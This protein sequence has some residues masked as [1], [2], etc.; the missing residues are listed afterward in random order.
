MERRAIFTTEH[1][2]MALFMV[3]ALL[4]NLCACYYFNVGLKY[5][6]AVVVMAWAALAF[7]IHPD[8]QRVRRYIK[9]Y[10]L[11]YFPFL[12]F[13]IWS[14]VIWISSFQTVDYIIRGSL[15]TIYM[16]T[17]VGYVVG[18]YYLF[19]E[20]SIYMNF[21]AMCLANTVKLVQTMLAYGP[22]RLF[23]EYVTL[24]TSFASNTG[25][26]ISAM[27]LHDMVFGFGPYI[28][29]FLLY[30]K[31]GKLRLGHLLLALFYFTLAMKRIAIA[32]VILPLVLILPYMKMKDGARR[33]YGAVLGYGGI[34]LVFLYLWTIKEGIFYDIVETLG[35]NMMSRDEFYARYDS[36][37]EL[38]P[39]FLGLGVRFV[40]RYEE[41]VQGVVH[42][43]HNIFLQMYIEVGFWTWFV[44][45]WY[46]VRF[47]I[48][49]IGKRVGFQAVIFLF[50]GTIYMWATFTTDNT[51]YYW[52]PNVSFMHLSLF[53]VEK[54]IREQARGED[55]PRLPRRRAGRLRITF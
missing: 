53:W 25:A 30:R 17:A 27:E 1:V 40:Y 2:G 33:V 26:G 41:A 28:L 22:V 34:L 54:T 4:A 18:S 23:S 13:W 43:I 51:L 32:A 36:F 14:L 38:T 49:A 48:Y 39:A 31:D 52:P 12:L 37:Y 10:L 16:A 15:N 9:Y 7:A 5:I 19:G 20:K 50:A 3:L 11:F 8:F 6:V 47:R 55:G 44:W 29:F 35:I 45:L 24:L 42:Q 46:E 21:Y